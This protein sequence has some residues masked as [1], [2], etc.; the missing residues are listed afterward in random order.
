MIYGKISDIKIYKGINKNLDKA[1]EMI[2]SGEYKNAPIGRNEIDGDNVYFNVKEEK[3]KKLEE[4]YFEVHQ[5]YIDIHLTVN[6]EEE[7]AYTEIEDLKGE[8]PYNEKSDM[9]ILKGKSA[10]KFKVDTERFIILFPTEPHMTTIA[11]N[12]EPT[13]LKK[14]VFKIKY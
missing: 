12:D 14:V 13:N 10:C 6:G 1:I 7:I 3:S 2:E 4:C 5:R 8:T 11:L 9:E